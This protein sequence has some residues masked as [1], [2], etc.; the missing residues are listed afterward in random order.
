MPDG[1]LTHTPSEPLEEISLLAATEQQPRSIHA[2]SSEV[3]DQ[4]AA[5]EVV[6]RP[7]HL[8]KELVENALD[9]NATVI[10]VEFDNGGRRVRVSDNGFGIAA[11]QLG[12]ALSRHATSKIDGA[13][14]LWSLSTFGFRG[15]AL[16]SIAAVSRLVL[17]SR[18]SSGEHAFQVTAEFG[19]VQACQPTAG[20]RG[21]TVV[22]EDLF[23]NIPARL[24]F[25]KSEAGENSQIKLTLRAL[26]LANEHVEF[27]VRHK[28]KVE[29]MF[30]KATSLLDR[31]RAVLEINNLYSAVYEFEGYRCEAVFSSPDTVAG[32]TR[33][34]WIFVQGR[35]VQDR[36]LQAAVMEAYRALLM[37][38]EFPIVVIRVIAPAGELD[39]NIHPTKSQ[40][41]FR[42]PQTAFRV[43]NRCLRRALELA[44]WASSS[45]TQSGEASLG[46]FLPNSSMSSETA[47]K[48][49]VPLTVAE[50]TRPYQAAR[51]VATTVATTVANMAA[52]PEGRIHVNRSSASSEPPS[53]AA[54]PVHSVGR[55]EA[56]E[57]STVVF[58]KKNDFEPKLPGNTPDDVRRETS[59]LVGG[60][61]SRLQVLSQANL[62]YILAQDHDRLVLID[63]HAAHER[64]AYEKLMHNWKSGKVDA[65][66]LLMPVQFTVDDPE[67]AEAL[68]TAAPELEKLGVQLDLLGLQ[69]LALRSR[70]ALIKE[71]A[72][73]DSLKRLATE[74]TSYGDGFAFERK[75]SDIC[76]TMACHSVVRAGQALSLEQMRQLL[77]QMDEFPLSGFCPHGRPVS[78]DYPFS[79]LERDFGRTV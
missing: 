26:A 27:R 44:P 63:Q 59:N 25:L 75:I 57:F 73:I 36:S 16:A 22:I 54:S 5:G 42:D 13:D 4:I 60:T 29:F 3:V 7:A 8:V 51:D 14:E 17:K 23:A 41:K 69:T 9:A 19:R 43:V 40:V 32:N 31:A 15:E 1:P 67:A 6:E 20:N 76:A 21:T 56:A 77:I 35:W 38:G 2:L 30:S 66:A 79:K 34:I 11:N 46:G 10:E 53:F 49:G 61:W 33:G 50:L 39:V 62:T 37:H 72:I 58:Q 47:G 12:L 18:L 28:S 45:R 78:I 74:I 48:P 68:V 65:Q 70:P 64:V 55:F 71:T 24:K 52:N